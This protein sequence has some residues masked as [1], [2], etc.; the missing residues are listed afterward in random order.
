MTDEVIKTVFAD[1]SC[2]GQNE[3]TV[4]VEISGDE[5]DLSVNFEGRMTVLADS[6]S[7][8]LIVVIA[9]GNVLGVTEKL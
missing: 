7:D 3:F 5:E 1:F 2:D 9:S 6:S 4:S 8:G